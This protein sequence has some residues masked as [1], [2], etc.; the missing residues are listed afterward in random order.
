MDTADSSLNSTTS[1]SEGPAPSNSTAAIVG[2]TLGGI[3][4]ITVVILIMLI[5]RHKRKSLP[6]VVPF[7]RSL[8]SAYLDSE[9]FE[10]QKTFAP[11]TSIYSTRAPFDPS[12]SYFGRETFE[13]QRSLVTPSTTIDTAVSA[14][15]PRGYNGGHRMLGVRKQERGSRGGA[16]SEC[17]TSMRLD[18]HERRTTTDSQGG[19]TGT[20][21]I[22]S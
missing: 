7:Q 17:Y 19:R 18:R 15:K 8:T 20:S 2:G 11:S 16:P 21:S 13:T 14:H 12:S 10:S 6:S 3:A 5:R 9:L 1:A 22:T 4:L